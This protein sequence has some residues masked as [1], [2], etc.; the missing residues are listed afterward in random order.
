MAPHLFKACHDRNP[1]AGLESRLRHV[2]NTQT[3]GVAIR[4]GGHSRSSLQGGNT[5]ASGKM[6][7][8]CDIVSAVWV[9]RITTVLIV[10]ESHAPVCPNLAAVLIILV[11]VGEALLAKYP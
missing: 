10:S 7:M 11:A 9:G 1:H 2:F 5:A 3:P 4:R 8:R 6:S